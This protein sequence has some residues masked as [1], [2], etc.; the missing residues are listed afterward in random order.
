M[1]DVIN[2][3]T[4]VVAI[5]RLR[6]HPANPRQGDVG[7]IYDSIN[8]NGFYGAVVVQ[9]S[10]G[11]VLAGNHR[12]KAAKEAGLEAVPAIYVDVDDERAMRILLADNRTNDVASY[13]NDALADLL[14]HLASTPSGLTGTGYDGD[15]LDD[16][17]TD[18]GRMDANWADALGSLPSGDQGEWR[19]MSFIVR[20]ADQPEIERAIAG[21]ASD[22][23]PDLSIAQSRG[24]A[25]AALVCR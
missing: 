17:L 24:A 13:D 23:R 20:D 16:L 2:K 5:D 10:T 21:A 3:R 6:P 11:Y 22:F 25:L 9:E 7:A 1:P 12:L 8:A 14:E 15:A 19:T 18:L 4:E